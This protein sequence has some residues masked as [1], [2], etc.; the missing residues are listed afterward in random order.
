MSFGELALFWVS[1][2][3]RTKAS[4]EIDLG[5]TLQLVKAGTGGLVQMCELL[6]TR[7]IQDKST[8]LLEG[9]RWDSSL[10]CVGA[11]FGCLSSLQA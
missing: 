4:K 6:T 9:F 8:G 7:V 1:P 5:R 11:G 2:H 10:G 3:S